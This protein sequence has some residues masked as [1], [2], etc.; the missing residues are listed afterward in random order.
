[1]VERR[2]VAEMP[3]EVQGH[4]ILV[5]CLELGL[6]LQEI[7]PIHDIFDTYNTLII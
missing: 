5:K 4:R 3:S 6:A 1:M 2:T 7:E